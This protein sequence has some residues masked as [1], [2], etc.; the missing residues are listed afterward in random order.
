MDDMNE[1]DLEMLYQKSFY[2]LCA[3]AEKHPWNILLELRKLKSEDKSLYM[4][5][6]EDMTYL[7]G[8]CHLSLKNMKLARVKLE[9]SYNLS[10]ACGKYMAHYS[11]ACLEVEEKNFERAVD[12]L[13]DVL[14]GLKHTDDFDKDAVKFLLGKAKHGARRA[15]KPL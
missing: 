1:D 2:E 12:L 14:E 10:K 9:K 15:A 3:A 7:E 13:N 4:S 11:L 5:N 6:L 8:Y